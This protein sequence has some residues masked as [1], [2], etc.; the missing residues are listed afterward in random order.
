MYTK[1]PIK[2]SPSPSPCAR[3]AG[4]SQ[5]RRG[6]GGA[7][8]AAGAAGAAG[9][10][11][12]RAAP[13]GRGQGLGAAGRGNNGGE[14]VENWWRNGGFIWVYIEIYIYVCILE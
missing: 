13:P 4:R 1:S 3:H 11:R 8:E 2:H 6:A 9:G 10:G 12:S 7:A 5:Q 14:L